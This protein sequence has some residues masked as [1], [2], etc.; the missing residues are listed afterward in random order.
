MSASLPSRS[1]AALRRAGFFLTCAALVANA[2]LAAS[3]CEAS[4][5]DDPGADATV[6]SSTSAEAGKDGT[7]PRPEASVDGGNCTAVT[8]DCDIVLQDCPPDDKGKTQECVVTS[9]SGGFKTACRAVQPSQQLPKGRSCCPNAPGG[10]P[11]LPGL[12]CVGRPCQD[13]GPVTGRC[14]PAC[15]R[16]DDQV[17]GQSDPEGIAGL[18]D[19]VLFDTDS[20]TELHPTCSYRERCKPFGQEPCKPGQ[21][22]MVEDKVGSASCIS[23]FD[24]KVGEPCGFSNDCGDGLFCLNTGDGGICRM[25]CLTPN[26]VHPFDASVEEGG[27]GKGG[28]AAGQACNIG[29]FQDLPAWLSFCRIDGG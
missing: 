24:K 14:A 17:C 1:L 18:C 21:M 10:N 29:P 3:A 7:T 4:S 6:E 20:N 28:C 19:I 26:S 16:G 13:G 9:A 15:C 8:G 22:C 5:P 23:T 27:P 12:T 25:M 11:C 2:G